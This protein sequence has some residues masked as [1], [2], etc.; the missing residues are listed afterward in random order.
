[1]ATRTLTKPPAPQDCWNW[2]AELDGDAE[3]CRYGLHRDGRLLVSGSIE[4]LDGSHTAEL[5]DQR[6]GEGASDLAELSAAWLWALA[7]CRELML[8]LDGEV[9]WQAWPDARGGMGEA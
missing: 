5:H 9:G 2:T 8:A 7:C 4:D 6:L 1:M 3:R